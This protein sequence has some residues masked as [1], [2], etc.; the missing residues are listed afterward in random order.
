MLCPALWS[1]FEL[2]CRTSTLCRDAD[3]MSTTGHP[4]S[5]QRLYQKDEARCVAYA[6]Y[7]VVSGYNDGTFP[8]TVQSWIVGGQPRLSRPRR[9]GTLYTVRANLTARDLRAPIFSQSVRG[10]GL[11][12]SEYRIAWVLTPRAAGFAACGNRAMHNGM[13]N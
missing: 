13:A 12:V 11:A 8:Y 7:T 5:S 4:S 10:R 9:G 6:T 1:A 2:G 3:G